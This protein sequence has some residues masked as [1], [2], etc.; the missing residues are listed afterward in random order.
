MLQYVLATLKT[1]GIMEF[2]KID[3]CGK[4]HKSFGYCKNHLYSYQKYGDP[5]F[6]KQIQYHGL[7]TK[8]RLEIRSVKGSRGCIEFT[9]S[10]DKHGYG[11]L[12]INGVPKLVTRLSWEIYKGPIPEGMYI[13]HRCDNP[14]CFNPEHL[15]LGTQQDN[16]DDMKTKGRARKAVGEK[17]SRAK[18]TDYLVLQIRASNIS[19]KELAKMYGV[20]EDTIRS[21]KNRDTWKHI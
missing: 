3:G 7:T 5:L 15:F 17:A 12:N 16:V 2:C 4:L 18:L 6:K 20:H 9:G 10:K 8:E 13:L 19:I 21:I 11:R 14:R 1:K